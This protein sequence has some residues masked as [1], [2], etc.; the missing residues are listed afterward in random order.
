MALQI[1]TQF[2]NIPVPAAY[3]TVGSVC[4]PSNS[5]TEV[6]FILHYRADKDAPAAFLEE[7]YS[8]PYSLT[9]ADPYTQAYMHLKSLPEFAGAVG[10]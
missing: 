4:F 2:Q 1:R 9:G 6:A 10:C 3:C 5:K 7:H 8:A